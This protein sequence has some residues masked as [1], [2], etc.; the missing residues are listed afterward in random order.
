MDR[1][2]TYLAHYVRRHHPYT[3]EASRDEMVLQLKR[4]LLT[5][6]AGSVSEDRIAAFGTTRG[7]SAQHFFHF[8]NLVMIAERIA[9]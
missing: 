6:P 2:P 3:T 1:Y 9:A 4:R 7:A 5:P 8:V